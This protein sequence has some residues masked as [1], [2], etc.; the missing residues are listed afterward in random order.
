MT[1]FF[2]S[3]Y[4][5]PT[6][7]YGGN[8]LYKSKDRGNTWTIISPDL[9]TN[10]GPER[11]GNIPFG[12]I[13]TLSESKLKQ[14]LIYAGTD[15]GNIQLTKDDGKSWTKIDNELPE[16]WVT[17]VCASRHRLSR[18]YATMTGYREDDFNTYIY[19]SDD[20]GSNWKPLAA[21][22]PPEPVN[23]IVEDP[24]SEDIL[25]IGTD[26]GAFVTTDRGESWHSLCNNLPTTPVYYMVI[27]DREL[28]LVAGTHGRSVF[29]LDIEEIDE[30]VE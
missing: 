5:P 19:V 29:V 27:Q 9:S 15:D 6:M 12:T 4:D 25:Y 21:N 26:L 1:P 23:I 17:H 11:Q 16:K 24:R 20:Y 28:D 8:H 3:E 7:Y 30:G 13:T 14:G 2:L 18:V 22:L 10:P